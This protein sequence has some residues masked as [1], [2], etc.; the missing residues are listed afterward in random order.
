MTIMVGLLIGVY[1]GGC[2]PSRDLYARLQDEDPIVRVGAIRQAGET[3]DSKSVSHLVDRLTD[4]DPTVR[5]FAIIALEKITGRRLGY[6]SYAPLAE[7]VE[8]AGRW[9]QWLRKQHSGDQANSEDE[10]P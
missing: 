6:K 3:K 1:Q 8:A 7:R 4:G 2:M 10:R 5:L 9:R